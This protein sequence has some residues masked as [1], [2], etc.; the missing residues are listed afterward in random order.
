M[1]TKVLMLVFA[2]F[3]FIG[4]IT[5][6]EANSK[7]LSKYSQEELNQFKKDNLKE[8]YKLNYFVEKG[9]YIIEMPSK[10][11]E[12]IE[13]KKIN[14]KTGYVIPDYIITLEDLDDFNPLEYNIYR[15]SLK[16][17]YFRAGDTGYV[18][19]VQSDEDIDVA[20]T[21]EMRIKNIR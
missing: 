18:I 10:P 15:S 7:L 12:L 14:P 3:A 21:N 17:N 9:C 8:F 20:V 16:N 19:V 6:Q 11:I 4:I 5:A 13:L 1:K 2:S